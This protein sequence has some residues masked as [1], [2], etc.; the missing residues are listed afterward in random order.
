MSH[1]TVL[2]ATKGNTE[3][4]LEEALQP[5]HEYECTGIKDKYVERVVCDDYSEEE[6][7]ND[8]IPCFVKESGEVYC[9]RYDRVKAEPFFKRSGLGVGSNDELVLPDWLSEKDIPANEYYSSFLE[10]LKDWCGIDVD[11]EYYDYEDGVLYTYTNPNK[12]W[13]WWMIGGRWSDKLIKKD[14]TRCDSA[15]KQDIDF[16]AMKKASVDLKLPD[17]KLAQQAFAGEDFTSWYDLLS[18]KS[19]SRDEAREL[20]HSQPAIKRFKK[21]FDSPFASAEDF[22]MSESEFI[23]DAEFAGVSTFAVL[24]D[25]KWI[26]KGDMGWWGCVSNEKEKSEWRDTFLTA[27]DHIP[28]DYCLTVVDCHI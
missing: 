26:E 4:Q 10:Y 17:Y 2:V 6:F 22:N 15:I 3:K 5:F 27:L 12:K 8:T 18:D 20:Y 28:D 13:D 19:M 16:D 1:F 24:F 7:N 14:G 21:A 9:T 25:G 23:K 11:G